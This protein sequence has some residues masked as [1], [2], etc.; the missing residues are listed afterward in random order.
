MKLI[1]SI[2]NLFCGIAVICL[3]S[4]NDEGTWYLSNEAERYIIDTSIVSFRMEDN[5]GMSEEF[6]QCCNAMEQ[7]RYFFTSGECAW[8]M[9]G[10]TY[11]SSINNLLFEY[12]LLSDL[13]GTELEIWWNYRNI[14]DYNIDA[15]KISEGFKPRVSFYDTLTVRNI[16]YENII[17]IDY[18]KIIDELEPGTPQKIYI[19]GKKGLIKLEFNNDIALERID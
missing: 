5:Y 12:R 8:E 10:I 9:Y 1:Q 19:S 16:V 4:C 3:S 13:N 2:I 7:Y 17:E 14:L 11:S 18:R 15:K 6:Q